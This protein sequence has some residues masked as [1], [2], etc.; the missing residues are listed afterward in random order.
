MDE[1]PG[2]RVLLMALAL[3]CIGRK[4]CLSTDKKEND[5]IRM[6]ILLALMFVSVAAMSAE[7]GTV[8]VGDA[9]ADVSAPDENG[10]DIK[11]SDYKGKNGLVIFFYPKADTPGCTK[12]ACN[13]RDQLPEIS[14]KGYQPLGVS[15]DKPEA[16][17]AFKE[18]Y[19]L[20]Y[21]L[22]SD[23]DG[24]VAAALGVE[25]GKRQT[26]IISKDGKIEKI[27]TQVQAATH[28]TDVL[29]ELK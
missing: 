4:N 9:V 24:K 1:E 10:K 21:P 3:P 25:P 13:F 28:A 16:Q 6:G 29:K 12:E 2:C 23:P 27:D 5:M 19:N 15:R 18:K 22:L 17:K 11:L 26:V 14:K 7:G 20:T 8:K